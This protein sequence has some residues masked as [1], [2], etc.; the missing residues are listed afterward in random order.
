MSSVTDLV[1]APK[2][3]EDCSEHWDSRIF[4]DELNTADGIS[5]IV[6]L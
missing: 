2:K 1:E 4:T 5:S 6:L 3:N